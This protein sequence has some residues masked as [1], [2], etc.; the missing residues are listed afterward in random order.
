M[1]FKKPHPQ[2]TS[3]LLRGCSS[4]MFI[5]FGRY[6][7]TWE[8]QLSEMMYDGRTMRLLVMI[9]KNLSPRSEQSLPQSSRESRTSGSRLS[10][11][12][13]YYGYVRRLTNFRTC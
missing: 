10:K 3:S 13:S 12:T 8:M 1:S 5:R 11:P 4:D 7:V 9:R 6:Y 2:M